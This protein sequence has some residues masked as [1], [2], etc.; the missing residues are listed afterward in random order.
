MKSED[1]SYGADCIMNLFSLW[2][3]K[4]ERKW[5]GLGCVLFLL[6]LKVEVDEEEIL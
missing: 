4:M 6:L 2:G 3:K 1:M 5:D